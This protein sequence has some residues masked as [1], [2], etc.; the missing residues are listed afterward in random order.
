MVAARRPGDRGPPGGTTR[1][2]ARQPGRQALLAGAIP[3]S[4]STSRLRTTGTR[5]IARTAAVSCGGSLGMSVG[6]T[7]PLYGVL[8]ITLALLASIAILVLAVCLPD[9]TV[10]GY[11]AGA[12]S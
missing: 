12:A 1:R 2:P 4:S 11:T 6:I 8:T 10:S 5:A 7:H 3:V 9:S